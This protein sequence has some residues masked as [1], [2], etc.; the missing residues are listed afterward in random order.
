MEA[1]ALQPFR[2]SSKSICPD[3][4]LWVRSQQDRIIYTYAIMETSTKR[5]WL[6]DH[7]AACGLGALLAALRHHNGPDDTAGVNVPQGWKQ[8]ERHT[9]GIRT[10][11][12]RLEAIQYLETRLGVASGGSWEAGR[13]GGRG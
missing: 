5:V 13:A 1:P 8:W 4:F 10:A 12:E 2:R 9:L 3:P 11:E 6:V 7:E